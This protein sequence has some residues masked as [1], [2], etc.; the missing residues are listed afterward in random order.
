LLVMAGFVVLTAVL[1]AGVDF[2]TLGT[3]GSPQ[4]AAA[5]SQAGIGTLLG[6]SIM[7]LCALL[8]FFYAPMEATM[9]AWATTYLGNKGLSEGAASGLLS[10]YWLAYMASRLAAAYTLP[11]GSEKAAILALSVVCVAIWAVVV[12]S[13]GRVLAAA[14]VVVAGAV[15]GPIYPTIM[16]VLLGHFDKALHGRAV[17]LLFAVGGLGWTALPMLIGAYAQRRGVQRGFLMAA[18]SAV[19]LTAIA[20]LLAV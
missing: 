18:A 9:G 12:A 4:A 17:G 5:P 20:L 11:G 19:G 15:F 8:L 10:G 13:R 6:D 7:W 16:A 2:S 1:A 14:M 3:T